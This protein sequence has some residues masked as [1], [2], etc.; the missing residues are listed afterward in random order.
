MKINS[1]IKLIGSIFIIVLLAL[2][3]V[4]CSN[5][6][7]NKVI[8]TNNYDIGYYTDTIDNIVIVSVVV[9]NSCSVGV[10]SIKLKEL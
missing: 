2:V 1:L 4:N 8:T 7:N 10:S 9:N 5:K 3:A 6:S